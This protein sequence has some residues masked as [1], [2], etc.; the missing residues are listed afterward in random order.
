MYLV[1]ISRLKVQEI[2]SL[3]VVSDWRARE[4]LGPEASSPLNLGPSPP[5][6]TV[7]AAGSGSVSPGLHLER[8]HG[9]CDFWPCFQDRPGQPGGGAGSCPELTSAARPP[10]GGP[11]PA[12]GLNS[13]AC[14]GCFPEK[15][16]R[17][18]QRRSGV[19]AES[20]DL[21]LKNPCHRR[22]GRR[23]AALPLSAGLRVRWDTARGTQDTC[24]R[25]AC[26]RHHGGPGPGHWGLS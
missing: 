14:L 11:E 4:G 12:V 20:L 13:P 25:E 15:W 1:A 6:F 2:R 24:W 23:G 26:P 10:T 8:V 16:P 7:S 17:P 18:R 9:G 3:P 22:G 5:G 19:K 21:Q